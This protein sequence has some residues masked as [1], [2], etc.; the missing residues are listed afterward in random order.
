MKDFHTE[1]YKVLINEVANDA[2]KWKD[3]PCSW[4]RRINII[5]IAVLLKKKIAVLLKEVYRFNVIS[6]KSP[7]TFF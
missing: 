5:K 2:K 4:I 1:N 3:I 7:M 6:L